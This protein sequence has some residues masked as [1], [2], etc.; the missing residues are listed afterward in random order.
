MT[1]ASRFYLLDEP[2]KSLIHGRF[3]YGAR[4]DQRFQ[5]QRRLFDAGGSAGCSAPAA[6]GVLSAYEPGDAPLRALVIYHIK[7]AVSGQNAG[8]SVD[9]VFFLWGMLIAEPKG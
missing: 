7:V 6:I 1:Q 3:C 5:S 8:G 9:R 2:A 4:V